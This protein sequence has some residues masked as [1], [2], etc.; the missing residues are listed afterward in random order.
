MNRDQEKQTLQ[1]V[2]NISCPKCGVASFVGFDC[3]EETFLKQT[4]GLIGYARRKG[5]EI[6]QFDVPDWIHCPACDETLNADNH[7]MSEIITDIT[8]PQS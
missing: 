8:A 5:S 6:A 4:H 3:N 2:F 7:N 1:G